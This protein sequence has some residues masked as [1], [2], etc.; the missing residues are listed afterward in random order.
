MTPQDEQ[1]QLSVRNFINERPTHRQWLGQLLAERMP[2]ITAEIDSWIEGRNFP[3]MYIRM[4][5]INAF[6]NHRCACACN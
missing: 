1:F 5:I 3:E 4:R 6:I 2:E